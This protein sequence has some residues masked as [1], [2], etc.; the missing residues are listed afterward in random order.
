MADNEQKK[1]TEEKYDLYTENIVT[2]PW[3]K[4]KRLIQILLFCVAAVA[5]GVIVTLVVTYLYPVINNRPS[6]T[7]GNIVIGGDD[8]TESVIEGSKENESSEGGSTV[9]VPDM[10]KVADEARKS[11]VQIHVSKVGEEFSYGTN[12]TEA[13]DLFAAFTGIIIARE[14]N[15]YYVL[16]KYSNMD[17]AKI[18]AVKFNDGN[19][20]EAEFIGYHKN[21][22]MAMLC[23]RVKGTQLISDELVDLCSLGT[24]YAVKSGDELFVMGKILGNAESMSHGLCVSNS[25]SKQLMDMGIGLIKTDIATKPGDDGFIFNR[26]G[27]LVGIAAGTDSENIIAYGISDLKTTIEN[28]I[29]RRH[30]PYVGV[31][32]TTVTQE[33]QMAYELPEGIFVSKI[34]RDS[35]AFRSGLQSG[36]VIIAANHEEIHT[37]REMSEVILSTTPGQDILFTVMRRSGEEYRRVEFVVNVANMSSMP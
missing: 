5:F 3:L 28:L 25:S 15:E 1:Q 13:G 26:Q 11:L 31:Y 23:V 37:V 21:T 29:N 24:S 8:E 33:I 10:V 12:E 30:M 32:G 19:V 20:C 7:Y 9:P 16:T 17:K 36:D 27:K 34:E 6:E 2:K 18:I 35:P 22:N 4:Y 14:D